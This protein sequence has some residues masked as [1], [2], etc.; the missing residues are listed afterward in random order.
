MECYLDNAAT[1]RPSEA[2]IEIMEK[3]MREDYGNPSSLHNKGFEAERYVEAARGQ[4]AKTLHAK[5]KEI[6][7]TSGGTESNNQA[8]LGSAYTKRRRGKH[9]ISTCFEHASVYQ[10][11]EFLRKEGFD[12]SY[13]SVDSM[14]HVRE[15]ALLEKIRPDTIL[16]SMMLVNNEVGS[17]VDVGRLSKLAR[18]R[19]PEIINYISFREARIFMAKNACAK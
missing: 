17:I 14:G 15:D 8:I 16:L 7:F 18:E 19:N 6:L 1:T 2:V 11:T 10:P 13:L 3:T 5:S 4:I 9:I 12:V